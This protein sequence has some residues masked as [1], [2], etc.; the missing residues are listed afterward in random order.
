MLSA[1]ITASVPVCGAIH[2]WRAWTGP[3]LAV[4]DARTFGLNIHFIIGLLFVGTVLIVLA[5]VTWTVLRALIAHRRMVRSEEQ[6][7]RARL[8]L[9]PNL[10]PPTER[11]L[12][13]SC[14]YASNKVYC[15]PS[16]RRLCE[17]CYHRLPPQAR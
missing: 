13:D 6:A 11:G 16:D 12:C 2:P 7:R 14:G 17:T 1:T 3:A 8:G 10:P 9:D 5:L 15:L 4:V